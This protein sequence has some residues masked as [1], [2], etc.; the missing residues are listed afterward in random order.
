MK[1]VMSGKILIF[2]KVSRYICTVSLL[3][4]HM[5]LKTISPGCGVQA[6]LMLFLIRD[7]SVGPVSRYREHFAEIP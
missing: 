6:S 4:Y 5:V 2:L 7:G 1:F 3:L